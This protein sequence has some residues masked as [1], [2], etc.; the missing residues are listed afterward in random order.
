MKTK[1]KTL[2][3]GVPVFA[4]LILGILISTWLY[5][6]QS[7]EY[8]TQ[9][10]LS[11]HRA[12]EKEWEDK[13]NDSV[14]GAFAEYLTAG[15]TLSYDNSHKLSHIVGEILYRT[16]GIG[17]IAKCTSDFAFGCYH[18]FAG[19]ALSARG[20]SV[21]SDIRGA[22]AN[23][24]DASVAFGCIHG[25]GH[26]ILSYLGNR[27]LSRAL[28]ACAPLSEGLSEVGGCFGGVFMEY[29]YN[30][31]KSP[32]GIELRPFDSATAYEPCATEIPEKFRSACYYD[33]ASWWHASL[34]KDNLTP[35]ESY[36][37]VGALCANVNGSRYRDMCYRGTGN[38]IG[39]G[40]VYEAPVMGKW[41][42]LMPTAEAQDLCFHEALQ[43]LLQSEK[44]KKELHR[45]CSSGEISYD[46]LCS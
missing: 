40:S 42:G 35:E 44:G 27:E 20:L 14:E 12:L 23:A 25:I 1:K 7:A 46:N 19:A 17:G 43:H 45:L 34:G 33:Q 21:L 11:P 15:Q 13:F 39:P 22:C 4:A 31:M 6:A 32:D 30:T 5:K 29:N 24:G 36:A 8:S 28:E 26:G 10:D 16:S 9:E 37:K 18:G 3:V 41:C 2:L 38:V